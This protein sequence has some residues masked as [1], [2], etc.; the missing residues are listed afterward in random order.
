MSST[1]IIFWISFS[2]LYPGIF[3]ISYSY[4]HICRSLFPI[5]WKRDST[6]PILTLPPTRTYLSMCTQLFSFCSTSTLLILPIIS[7]WY[8]KKIITGTWKTF[9][10]AFPISLKQYFAICASLNYDMRIWL[11]FQVA[12]NFE[13]TLVIRINHIQT[14]RW[15]FPFS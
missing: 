3:R 14:V 5:S 2:N 7:I 10:V 12:I 15:T 11:R 8:S 13:L 9:L 1:H 4:P 6:I